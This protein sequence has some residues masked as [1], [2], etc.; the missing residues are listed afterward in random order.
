MHLM[1]LNQNLVNET[2]TRSFDNNANYKSMKLYSLKNKHHQLPSFPY[3]QKFI[4]YLLPDANPRKY[5]NIIWMLVNSYYLDKRKIVY[6]IS[7]RS[8]TMSYE[9]VDTRKNHPH[10]HAIRLVKCSHKIESIC[11]DSQ[12]RLHCIKRLIAEHCITF[13]DIN[14]LNSLKFSENWL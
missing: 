14:Q 4:E 7:I 8:S 9:R 10:Y 11:L 6:I 3:I 12:K 2:F 13:K 1:L 5:Y